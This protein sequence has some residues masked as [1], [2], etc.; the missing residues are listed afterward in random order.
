[1]QNNFQFKTYDLTLQTDI[2]L[3]NAEVKPVLLKWKINV[4][5]NIKMFTSLGN[6]SGSDI[7]SSLCMVDNTII[8]SWVLYI[9]SSISWYGGFFYIR[10]SSKLPGIVG[11][12]FLWFE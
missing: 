9:R 10:G 11:S 4:L 1:M 8:I 5:S 7:I 3:Y 12:L 6:V 2:D